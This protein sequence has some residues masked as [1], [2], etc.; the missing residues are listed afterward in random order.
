MRVSTPTRIALRTVALLYLTVL[1]AVPIVTIVWRTFEPGFGAFARRLFS[2]RWLR[3][4]RSRSS[5]SFMNCST[6]W[7]ERYTD[8]KRT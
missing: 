8:A 4:S 6:S 3:R 5:S 1:L 2:P 7:N